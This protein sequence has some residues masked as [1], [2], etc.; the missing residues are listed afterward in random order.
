MTCVRTSYNDV[1][2][3]LFWRIKMKHFSLEGMHCLIIVISRAY[4][5]NMPIVTLVI[6]L[7]KEF[8]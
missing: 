5:G 6:V 8:L 1:A 7:F 4:F 3:K 2:G